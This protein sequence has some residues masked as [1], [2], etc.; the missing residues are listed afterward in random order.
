MALSPLIKRLVND[1]LAPMSPLQSFS[2][3]MTTLN[4]NSNYKGKVWQFERNWWNSNILEHL[5]ESTCVWMKHRYLICHLLPSSGQSQAISRADS[6]PL[7]PASSSPFSSRSFGNSLEF[8]PRV[9]AKCERNLMH[10]SVATEQP[11]NGLVHVRNFRRSPCQTYGN[12]TLIT[13]LT[14]DLLAQTNRPNFC[15]VHRVKVIIRRLTPS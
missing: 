1:C 11:F 8:D 12:G 14:I 3:G 13:S 15:G 10:I 2:N 4:W 9:S 7:S 6:S 5:S